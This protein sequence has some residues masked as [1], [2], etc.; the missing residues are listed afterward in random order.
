MSLIKS[1]II[2]TISYSQVFNQPLSSGEIW[3]RCLAPV[4]NWLEFKTELTKLSNLTQKSGYWMRSDKTY[5]ASVRQ[6]RKQFLNQKIRLARN[7]ANKVIKLPFV[8]QIYLTGSLAAANS[9]RY[10]DIDVLVVT[11]PGSLWLVRLVV[12]LYTQ[13]LE[14]RRPVWAGQE[15][16]QSNNKICL[17]MYIEA[18]QVRLDRKQRNLYTAFEVIQAQLLASKQS[19]LSKLWFVSQNSWVKKHLPQVRIVSKFTN[20]AGKIETTTGWVKQINYW[21]YQVQSW[22]MRSRQTQERIELGKALF[23]PRNTSSIIMD[24]YGLHSQVSR[25]H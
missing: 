21:L 1:G 4:E 11:K 25:H 19:G 2:K 22:Y 12:T 9:R 15:S 18:D 16:W 17:N 24:Q 8:E 14:L 5:L 20:Q 6:Y 23:H 3:Q 13:W 7:W 10:D